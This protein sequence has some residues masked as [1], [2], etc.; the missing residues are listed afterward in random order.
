MYYV[1]FFAESKSVLNENTLRSLHLIT[2][3]TERLSWD[4]IETFTILKGFG[5]DSNIVSY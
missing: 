2:L 5:L 4:L 3:E 1:D